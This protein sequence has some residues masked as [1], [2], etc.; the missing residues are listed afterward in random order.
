[1][2]VTIN[3]S[4]IVTNDADFPE[5]D[6][7]RSDYQRYTIYTQYHE[8]GSQEDYWYPQELVQDD[9][10]FV[11]GAYFVMVE[12]TLTSEDAENWTREDSYE[13]TGGMGAWSDPYIFDTIGGV[14]YPDHPSEDTSCN[15]FSELYS[16]SKDLGYIMYLY[17]GETKTVVLGW[18]IQC[19]PDTCEPY[20]YEDLRYVVHYGGG[21]CEAVISLTDIGE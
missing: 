21:E 13:T 10:S 3:R 16:V 14:W 17:P 1:M 7:I 20:K 18:L 19:D 4:W 8:D 11:G 12:L 6:R 15:Y 2:T 5:E 9:G